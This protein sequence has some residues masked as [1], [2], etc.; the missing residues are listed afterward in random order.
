MPLVYS[1]RR[2][3]PALLAAIAWLAILL[4]LWLSVQL[5]F[6]NGKSLVGGLVV[7]FGFFTV[8]SNIFVALVAT[9]GAVGARSGTTPRLY[10]STVVGCATASI[11]MVGIVYHLVLRKIWSPQ[12]AQ[13]LADT[14]LHYVVPATA[15][16]HWLLYRPGARLAW[17]APL[18]W[19]AYPLV[20][21]AYVL[22][23]G[24][25]LGAY[26]YP[27]VDVAAL[28]YR[29]VLVHSVG[30]MVAFI[31]LGYAVLGLARL[32]ARRIGD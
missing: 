21:L 11:L 24:E 3:L 25:W 16:L 28:G 18:L 23:R 22:L 12:G 5:G 7:F 13:W 9:S 32:L 14:L 2:F 8:L 15:L 26:P 17:H 10:R 20:Y 31:V 1:V 4:Q 29:Q 30:L 6:A 27:F 19:C